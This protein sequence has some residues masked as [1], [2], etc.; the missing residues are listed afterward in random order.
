VGCVFSIDQAPV[1]APCGSIS[2]LSVDHSS[3]FGSHTSLIVRLKSN[4]H[5]KVV[6]SAC[7]S[8]LPE[9]IGRIAWG[10]SLLDEVIASSELG[11]GYS[12]GSSFSNSSS[13]SR[14]QIFN[15]LSVDNYNWGRCGSRSWS[16]SRSNGG[17]CDVCGR[18]IDH[19]FGCLYTLSIGDLREDDS[20]SISWV[21]SSTGSISDCDS[22]RSINM[23]SVVSNI[24]S[25]PSNLDLSG[26]GTS[27]K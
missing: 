12:V 2:V 27:S 20:S 21:A 15:G 8:I 1:S 5:I 11:I 13:K 16:R 9:V 7:S 17:I 10:E 19:G 22:F 6:D 23:K 3:G 4:L 14:L 25:L 26:V 18:I 24:G